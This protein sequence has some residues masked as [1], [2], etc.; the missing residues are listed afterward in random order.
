MQ[1]ILKDLNNYTFIHMVILQHQQ[2]IL[3]ILTAFKRNGE[4]EL[5]TNGACKVCSIHV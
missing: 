1:E 5:T 2:A 3:E 4:S